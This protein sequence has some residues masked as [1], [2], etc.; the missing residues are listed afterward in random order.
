MQKDLVEKEPLHNVEASSKFY[1]GFR[2]SGVHLTH[3]VGYMEQHFLLGS[4]SVTS[5]RC[6]WLFILIFEYSAQRSPRSRII[7]EE[8]LIAVLVKISYCCRNWR[9]ITVFCSARHLMQFWAT[10][11]QLIISQPCLLRWILLLSS[12]LP[13]DFLSVKILR[14]NFCV[15]FTSRNVRTAYPSH[16]IPVFSTLLIFRDGR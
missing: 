2:A 8:L 9:L 6:S 4:T 11:I 16:V 15:N 5:R 12:C 10:E 7:F 13:S 1:W 14:L 3:T